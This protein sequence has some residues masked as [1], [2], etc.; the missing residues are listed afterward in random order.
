MANQQLTPQ[1]WQ[2]I[3]NQ[4]ENSGLTISVFCKQRPITLSNFLQ[5]LSHVRNVRFSH[6]RFCP[7][8]GFMFGYVRSLNPPQTKLFD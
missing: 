8:F 1:Q 4:Q 6:V 3:I 5:C 7:M 2:Q